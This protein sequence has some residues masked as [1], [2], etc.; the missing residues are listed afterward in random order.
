LVHNLWHLAPCSFIGQGTST[1]RHEGIFGSFQSLSQ[2]ATY[3]Y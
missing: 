2:V 3:Y 1:R